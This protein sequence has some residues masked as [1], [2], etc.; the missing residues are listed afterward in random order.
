MTEHNRGKNAKENVTKSSESR[1]ITKP[2]C[3]PVQ[4]AVVAFFLLLSFCTPLSLKQEWLLEYMKHSKV[5]GWPSSCV[6]IHIYRNTHISVHILTSIHI[7]ISTYIFETRREGGVD[8][9]ATVSGNSFPVFQ[10]WVEVSL[11]ILNLNSTFLT[12]VHPVGF[13]S[14]QGA[15]LFFH[16]S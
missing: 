4:K 8:E 12:P 6:C 11:A 15:S 16:F 10:A 7:C 3:N 13:W 1:T 2:K 5:S 14:T 9:K